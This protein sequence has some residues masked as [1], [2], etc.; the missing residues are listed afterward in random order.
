MPFPLAYDSAPTGI[1]P[2]LPSRRDEVKRRSRT[3]LRA[4]AEELIASAPAE[5]LCPANVDFTLASV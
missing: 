4:R 2:R 3:V 1:D 5:T